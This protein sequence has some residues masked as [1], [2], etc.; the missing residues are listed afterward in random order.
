VKVDDANILFKL[1]EKESGIYHTF[2]E[3]TPNGHD[4]EYDARGGDFKTPLSPDLKVEHVHMLIRKPR[5]YC[6]EFILGEDP[7]HPGRQFRVSGDAGLQDDRSMHLKVDIAGLN[8]AP[9]LPAKMRAHV[10]GKISGRFDY[11]SAGTGLETG[12]GAGT[13]DVADGVLREL[14]PIHQYVVV[15]GSPDPGPIR[16]KVCR[17]DVKWEA[18]AITAENLEVESEGFFRITGTITVAPDHTLSGQ[19]ELGLTDSYLKW[20][21]T[22]RPAIFTRDEGPYHFTTI[23]LS[24]TSQK[25][26]QDLTPRITHEIAKS[27]LLALKLFFNSAGTWF[28]PD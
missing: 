7:A 17:A 25:P 3:I 5:L 16:L 23:H 2:L 27:P 26:E 21:P 10:E 1:R 24:G 20:L 22:A 4:F 19:V 15:T 14:G 18:G 9:W 8:V 11:N 28:D 12:H 13:I 6:R